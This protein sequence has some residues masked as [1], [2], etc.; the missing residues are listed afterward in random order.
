MKTEYFIEK[1]GGERYS[2]NLWA[3]IEDT[4]YNVATLFYQDS[5]C[6]NQWTTSEIEKSVSYNTIEIQDEIESRLF[7]ISQ[8]RAEK[9]LSM[10]D[11]SP[12]EIGENIALIQS[13]GGVFTAEAI[14]IPGEEQNGE[15]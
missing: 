12:I 8:E 5:L 13:L 6:G 4:Y 11:S 9:I 7:K 14:E 1:L 2:F 3:K 10:K 15:I